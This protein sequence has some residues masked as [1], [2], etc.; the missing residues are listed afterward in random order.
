MS[1]KP[2]PMPG[3][4][5]TFSVNQ[6]FFSK[7][8]RQPARENSTAPSKSWRMTRPGAGEKHGRTAGGAEKNDLQGG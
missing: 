4:I 7:T 6:Y 2:S 8:R 1:G 5:S 3:P